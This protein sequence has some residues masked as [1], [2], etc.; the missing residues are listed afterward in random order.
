MALTGIAKIL[1]YPCSEDY[2]NRPNAFT[3][4]RKPIPYTETDKERERE[5]E[6]S[7]SQQNQRGRERKKTMG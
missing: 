7:G 2:Y 5:R 3:F 6:V 4:S 1:I